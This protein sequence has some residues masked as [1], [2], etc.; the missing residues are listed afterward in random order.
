MKRTTAVLPLVLACC[1]PSEAQDGGSPPAGAI[2]A[3]ALTQLVRNLAA[4]V[5]PN[6]PWESYRGGKAHER[7]EAFL[8]AAGLPHR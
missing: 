6:E 8:R 1:A 5:P 4:G 2:E 3:E 7:A